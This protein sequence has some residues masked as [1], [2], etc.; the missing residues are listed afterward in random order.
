LAASSQTCS[1]I[2]GWFASISRRASATM[3]WS[4][5]NRTTERGSARWGFAP[6]FRGSSDV[7]TCVRSLRVALSSPFAPAWLEANAESKVTEH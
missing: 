2:S 7:D 6:V 1:S 4:S 5:T 3:A